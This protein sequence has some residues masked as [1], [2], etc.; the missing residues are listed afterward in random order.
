MLEYR[1]I[2]HDYILN[3][4]SEI[5][6]TLKELV[7]IPSVRGE[8]APD[9]PFGKDCA[10]VLEY[11]E[12]LYQK[13]GFETEPDKD[14]GYLLSYF[15]EGQKS[16]GLFAH[17]DVVPV[18]DNWIL[19]PP[20]EPIE[21]DGF[22]LGRGVLDDK[23]AIVISLYC[24]K[25]LKELNIPFNSRLVCFI[26]ANEESGM[27]DIENYTKKHQAPDF[28]LVCDTGFPL[29]RGN[30]GIMRFVATADNRFEQITDFSGG[31]S[32]NI[33]LGK[34]TARLIYSA[35]LYENLK[36]KQNERIYICAENDEIVV[37]T[38]GISKHGA[39]PEGSLNAGYILTEMLSG[40]EM[41]NENDRRQMRFIRDLLSDYYG[42]A[43]GID[44]EDNQ[45]GKLTC[46]NGM[47][48]VNAGK[49]SLSFDVRFGKCADISVMQEKIAN[50]LNNKNWK[51]EFVRAVNAHIV[52]ENNSYIQSC[53]NTYKEYTGNAEAKTYL[54]AGGTYAMHLPCAAEI[55]TTLRGGMPDGLP[56]GHGGAH[57]PDECIS[58]DGML[59]ALE[60][61]MLMLLECDK[62]DAVQ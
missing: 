14:G 6:G 26:G 60:L 52:D 7:R 41:L 54:N 62:E 33:I 51:A 61:T 59:E 46:T 17:A 39:L 50:T 25:M 57:Q 49:I 40:C 47:I 55:G 1:K 9:A 11:T 36:A 24:A 29:Y 8:T 35:M 13:N 53:L 34:A 42:V 30:K 38:E 4:R 37:V 56:Q 23:S 3:N 28:S 15:G 20:F 32:F 10:E 18:G 48:K 12:R 21:K 43:F 27:K 2:I 19:T 16:L 5:I 44:C 45:F 31:E 22:L 58:I